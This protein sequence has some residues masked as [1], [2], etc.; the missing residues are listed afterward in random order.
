MDIE[1]G[2]FK[3]AL[4]ILGHMHGVEVQVSHKSAEEQQEI[5]N[6]YSLMKD[7]RNFYTKRIEAHENIRQYLEERGLDYETRK[8][9]GIGFSDSGLELH[10]YLK[11]K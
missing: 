5:K 10:R 4:E 11:G 7:A 1:N 3:E 2:D 8:A 9:W 6:I